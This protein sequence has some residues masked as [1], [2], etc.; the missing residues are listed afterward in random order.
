MNACEQE[1][2][3]S[4]KSA[5]RRE[6]LIED[7]MGPLET[8]LENRKQASQQSGPNQSEFEGSLISTLKLPNGPFNEHA[9]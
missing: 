3:R 1:K 6:N 8:E 2:G 5:C 9:A 7:E 4:E